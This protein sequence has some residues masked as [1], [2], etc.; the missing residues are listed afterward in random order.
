MQAATNLAGR[1][2]LDDEP[3]P[4]HWLEPEEPLDAELYAGHRVLCRRFKGAARP[5]GVWVDGKLLMGR[6]LR[7]RRR[8]AYKS[9][10]AAAAAGR[11]HVREMERS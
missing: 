10:A 9:R 4:E 8:L 11:K 2:L 6:G 5:W 1:P 7:V 3:I